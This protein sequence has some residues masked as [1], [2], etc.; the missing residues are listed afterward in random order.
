MFRRWLMVVFITTIF[1][2]T[3]SLAQAQ[4][5]YNIAFLRDSLDAIQYH[6]PQRPSINNWIIITIK[7][8][9]QWHNLAYI[10]QSHIKNG[11]QNIEIRIKGKNI[12][13]GKE[14]KEIQ[15]WN[16]PKANI[17]IVGTKAKMQPYGFTFKRCDK[18]AKVDNDF[19]SQSYLTILLLT[20][21]E[22]RLA[23][24]K[25]PNRCQET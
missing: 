8:Q 22:M 25:R 13:F 15:D 3:F 14:K 18:G 5:N 23:C 11:E 20:R 16:Y 24:V 4:N 9:E 12:E 2:S 6:T 10:L 19:Y 1:S 7:T 21:K 17:R